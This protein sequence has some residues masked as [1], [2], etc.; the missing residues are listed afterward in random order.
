MKL[1]MTPKRQQVLAIL[2]KV[3]VDSMPMTGP[4]IGETR[5]PRGGRQGL[6]EWA[7]PAL[8]ALQEAGLIRCCG[9]SSSNARCYEITPAGRALLAEEKQDA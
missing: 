8:N 5:F 7:M 9:T 4:E 1:T 3:P 2:G 6:R